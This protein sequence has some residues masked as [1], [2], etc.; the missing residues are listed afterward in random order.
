MREHNEGDLGWDLNSCAGDSCTRRSVAPS[1]PI[2]ISFVLS[3]PSS[4]HY[5]IV[6]LGASVP[7]PI[8]SPASTG[9][10]YYSAS[11]KLAC[12]YQTALFL[13]PSAN[14]KQSCLLTALATPLRAVS[15]NS[16][17]PSRSPPHR[18]QRT[19]LP[20]P[21]AAQ[22]SKCRRTPHRPPQYPSFPRRRA[23]LPSL[24]TTLASR[25]RRPVR[26]SSP[27]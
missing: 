25:P 21:P 11:R 5:A 7:P 13:F 12:V 20:S 2:K 23:P 16:P 10:P 26:P 1:L 15:L 19:Y 4:V 6:L 27:L 17:L 14:E 9:A 18:A 24:S 3:S 8:I 22:P